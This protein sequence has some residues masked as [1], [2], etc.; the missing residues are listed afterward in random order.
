MVDKMIKWI[1]SC[2]STNDEALTLIGDPTYDAVASMSQTQGR[3]RMGRT[4]HSPES[5][6][7][8]LS[9]L[10]QPKLPQSLGGAVPLLA[11]VATAKLCDE[12]NVRV[13]LK[14]PNDVLYQ[15]QKLAGILCEARTIGTRWYAVVG[16]GLN[17]DVPT[18]GWPSEL[19]AIGLSE[20]T[21]T[22]LDRREI[23]D[24]LVGYLRAGLEEATSEGMAAITKNWLA[25]GP[26]LGT[27]MKRGQ[28]IGRF[29]G[30][31]A[32]GSLRIETATGIELIHAGD[33][34]IIEEV[35]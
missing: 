24:K 27:P 29:S 6:G 20:V 35:D 26:P 8:Y 13:M 31:A 4:W 15:G 16:I 9:W 23:A 1:D 22:A 30:L 10:S 2:Q 3:G 12:L 14:W 19:S 33:V 34:H 32:D 7:L 21:E 25:Y 5:A 17:I 18:G 11:A 28:Q